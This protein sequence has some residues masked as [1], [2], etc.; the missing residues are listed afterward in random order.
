[1]PLTKT[2][3]KRKPVVIAWDIE[4]THNI[5]AAYSIG[6]YRIAPSDIIQERYMISAAWTELGTGRVRAVSVL[7]DPDGTD[8]TI[9]ETL[10]NVFGSA[11]AVVAHYGDKFDMR[12]FNSRVIY[13]GFDPAPP[14]IQIDTYKIAR[15]KFKFNSNKL[16]YL[17]QYLGLGRKTRT[18]GE[19]WRRCLRGE[20]KAIREM[21]AYNKQDIVLL[22]AVY[23]RLAPF[24]P[25]KV[26]YNLWSDIDCCP[27]CGST[28]LH[29][30]GKR[31]TT[32]RTYT[33]YQCQDCGKWSSGTKAIGVAERK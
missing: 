16:D 11:D 14:L 30:R 26:N 9:V 6:E 1:M 10:L 28:K 4:T 25:N 18:D 19:L 23:E 5:V 7:D 27:H 31:H 13:W 20:K 32:T 21:V 24:G 8:R 15:S 12:F 22:E 2:V 33:R 29:S 3:N 17:G